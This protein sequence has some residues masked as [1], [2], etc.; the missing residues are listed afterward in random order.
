[1][2]RTVLRPGYAKPG[3]PSLAKNL[4]VTDFR[5]VQTG[6]RRWPE[7]YAQFLNVIRHHLITRLQAL[8]IHIG[9]YLQTHMVDRALDQHGAFGLVDGEDRT[10]HFHAVLNRRTRQSARCGAS[11]AHDIFP[12]IDA[13]ALGFIERQGQCF[14]I[15]HLDDRTGAD[16]RQVPHVRSRMDGEN[17]AVFALDAD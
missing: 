4:L 17:L 3:L 1:M 9:G 5:Q 11:G 13:S 15:F 2:G 7:G 6:S 10:E 12:H 14:V 16:L 8:E